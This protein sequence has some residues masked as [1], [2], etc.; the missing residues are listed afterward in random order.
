MTYNTPFPKQAPWFIYGPYQANGHWFVGYV[1]ASGR[2]H[3]E[4]TDN[5]EVFQSEQ[6]ARDYFNEVDYGLAHANATT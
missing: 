1:V 5:L 2:L 3:L 4:T 6:D